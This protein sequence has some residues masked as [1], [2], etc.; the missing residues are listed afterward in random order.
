MV[1]LLLPAVVPVE[2]HDT[3][4]RKNKTYFT[5][6]V[7]NSSAALLAFDKRCR[8]ALTF[9]IPLAAQHTVNH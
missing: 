1:R 5:G 4:A 6:V 7:L 8:M 9:R 2:R 3:Q